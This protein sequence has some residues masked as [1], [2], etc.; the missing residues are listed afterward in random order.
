MTDSATAYL[1]I[2]ELINQ[3]RPDFPDITIS[4]IRFLEAE[5]LVTPHRAPSGYRR[6]SRDDVDR[7]RYVL[8]TQRDGYL[9]LRVIREH[10][11]AMDRGLEPP[12]PSGHAPAAPALSAVP[13]A[14][15]SS[16]VGIRRAPV[17]LTRTELLAD[18]G[19]DEAQLAQ[20]EQFGMIDGPA[21]AYDGMALVVARAVGKMARFGIEP[22]HLRALRT[23]ADREVGLY[24][25]V[26]IPMAR[27]R[28]GEAQARAR[29]T[30]QELAALSVELH[31]ALVRNR[32]R[33]V[34]SG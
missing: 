6:F 26:L 34:L 31:A 11:D 15:G 2:G 16:D 17:R 3:L 23:A 5:G 4:K 21:A 9:P 30:A 24:E 28:G 8:G 22:R 32:L 7:L 29:E 19:I 10:L 18:A 25:Q 12:A 33:A 14:P 1:S 13:W 27:Q 20:L